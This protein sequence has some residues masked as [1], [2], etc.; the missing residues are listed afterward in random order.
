MGTGFTHTINIT[1]TPKRKFKLT[2]DFSS[3]IKYKTF[4]IKGYNPVEIASRPSW[5]KPGIN[6]HESDPTKVTLVLHAPTYTRYKKGT[7]TIS[8]TGNTIPKNVVYVVGDF[9][10]WTA[11]ES[12]KMKRDRDGWDG[13]ADSDGDDDRG[14]YWWIEISGL[15]P[16]RN[17]YFNILL[18][19]FYRL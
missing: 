10:N 7:G 9:N 5:T 8:G 12:C 2:T 14:D 15:N 17:M 19:A 1:G 4:S 6:Y 16:D 18:T 3:T 11:S 13:T